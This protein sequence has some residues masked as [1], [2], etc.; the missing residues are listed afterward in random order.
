MVVGAF[1]SGPLSHSNGP[2][3]ELSIG[4]AQILTFVMTTIPDKACIPR[5]DNTNM[6]WEIYI[7]FPGCT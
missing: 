1:D 7:F 5:Q 6:E 4:F 3:D 2:Q